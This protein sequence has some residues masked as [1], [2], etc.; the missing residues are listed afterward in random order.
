MFSI[1]L[2]R[3]SIIDHFTIKSISKKKLNACI[4]PRLCVE[5]SNPNIEVLR[6]VTWVSNEVVSLRIAI[7]VFL[8]SGVLETRHRG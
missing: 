1:M 4:T 2:S 7:P 5:I 8:V 3:F 6:G